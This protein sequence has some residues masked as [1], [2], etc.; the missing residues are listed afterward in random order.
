M[1]LMIFSN[2]PW[3]FLMRSTTNSAAFSDISMPIHFRCSL[4]AATRVVAQP[5]NGSKT[6]LPLLDEAL[7]LPPSFRQKRYSFKEVIG[8]ALAFSI[9]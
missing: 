3:S 6:T 5:Q 2:N 8:Q 1:R 9:D 4:S 7:N